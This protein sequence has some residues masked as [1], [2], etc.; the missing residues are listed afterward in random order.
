MAK[1]KNGHF[2]YRRVEQSPWPGPVPHA[3][4]RFKFAGKAEYVAASR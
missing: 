4:V 2:A 3:I 1:V